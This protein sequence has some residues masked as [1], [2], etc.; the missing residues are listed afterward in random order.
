LHV[1]FLKS[2]FK[3]VQHLNTSKHNKNINLKAKSKQLFIKNSLENQNKQD[4]FPL[5][6]CQA[7]LESDI[8][9]GKLNHP[10]FKHF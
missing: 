8:P 2:K 4:N 3:R 9:L 10:S 1:F 5:D 7:M 6:L